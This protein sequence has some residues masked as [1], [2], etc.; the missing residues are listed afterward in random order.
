VK[1]PE[2]RSKPAF[3]WCE[4]QTQRTG[5]KSTD[6]LRCGRTVVEGDSHIGRSGAVRTGRSYEEA[7]CFRQVI[8]VF[9]I[10]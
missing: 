9:L 6:L 7:C 5:M 3:V 2:R 10:F 4:E 8:P 1:P